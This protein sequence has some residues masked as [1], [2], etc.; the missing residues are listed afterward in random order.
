[1]LDLTKSQLN[2]ALAN[3]SKP[4]LNHYSQS[5][6]PLETYLKCLLS[7]KADEQF[8][9]LL[10][11]SQDEADWF[12]ATGLPPQRVLDALRG[13]T[14]VEEPVED[15]LDEEQ[16]FDLVTETLGTDPRNRFH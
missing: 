4:V 11:T 3:F 16:E 7:Q 15:Y 6:Y 12:D 2:A 9:A 1:M 5:G 10:Q 8:L 13:K 14:P